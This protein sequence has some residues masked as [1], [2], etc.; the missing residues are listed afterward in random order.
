ME[1][2]YLVFGV[3]NDNLDYCFVYDDDETRIEG[4][5]PG[6]WKWNMGNIP[7][8]AYQCVCITSNF[9]SIRL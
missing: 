5:L 7:Y 1:G 8:S 6:S 4:T 9:N 2:V 3:Q